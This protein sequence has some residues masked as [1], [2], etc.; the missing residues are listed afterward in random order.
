MVIHV[1]NSSALLL[2]FPG[3]ALKMVEG[4]NVENVSIERAK[5]LI[6]GNP[7]SRVDVVL[8]RLTFSPALLPSLS[9]PLS[10]S[11]SLSHSLPFPPALPNASTFNPLPHSSLIL[12]LPSSSRSPCGQAPLPPLPLPV[13]INSSLQAIGTGQAAADHGVMRKRCISRA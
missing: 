7:G 11:L 1:V 4:R 9:F 2:S 12:F 13:R 6:L 5:K 10:R 8:L 3:D